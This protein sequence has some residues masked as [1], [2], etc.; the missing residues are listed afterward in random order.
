GE[1]AQGPV[2]AAIGNAVSRAL[3]LRMRDLPLTRDR[4]VDALM[5]A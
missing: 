2:A 4:L 5:G 1:A 3:G